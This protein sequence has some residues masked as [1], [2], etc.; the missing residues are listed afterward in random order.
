[1]VMA[2]ENNLG[3]PNNKRTISWTQLKAIKLAIVNFVT[4]IFYYQPIL[5]EVAAKQ[6]NIHGN[7]I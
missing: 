5:G 3:A 1:M 2:K 7:K 4:L 6:G